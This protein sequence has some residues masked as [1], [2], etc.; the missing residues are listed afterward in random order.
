MA[1]YAANLSSKPTVKAEGEELELDSIDGFIE[2]GV[3]VNKDFVGTVWSCYAQ[4]TGRSGGRNGVA[5]NLG[6][7]YKF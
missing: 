2:Y 6:I 7:K 5:G 3:G 4:V 1:G